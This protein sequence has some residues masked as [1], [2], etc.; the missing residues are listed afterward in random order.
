MDSLV[1]KDD[2][3]LSLGGL[4][5]EGDV[6]VGLTHGQPAQLLVRYHLHSSR[7]RVCPRKEIPPQILRLDED[8]GVEGR[9]VPPE[10]S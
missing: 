1:L 6:V 10:A 7:T 5:V 4:G 2:P 9:D 3:V 8:V